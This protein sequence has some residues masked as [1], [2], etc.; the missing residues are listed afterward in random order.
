MIAAKGN[1]NAYVSTASISADVRRTS[2]LFLTSQNDADR[3]SWITA[4]QPT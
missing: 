3:S 2:T 1:A 4:S